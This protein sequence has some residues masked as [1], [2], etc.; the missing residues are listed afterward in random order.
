MNQASFGTSAAP[1]QPSEASLWATLADP[2]SDAAYHA[3]WLAL[4]CQRAGQIESGLLVLR[5]ADQTLAP[6]AVW[7]HLRQDVRALAE[8]AE[9][10]L[11]EA[12]PVIQ[13]FAE[14]TGS[15]VALAYPLR[16][17]AAV[18][19]VVV[20]A[21][22]PK[23]TPDVGGIIRHMHWSAGLIEAAL[24]RH[25]ASD[26]QM[27]LASSRKVMDLLAAVQDEPRLA[28]AN[29]A[30]VNEMALATKAARVSLGI[31]RRSHA[32]LAALSNSARFDRNSDAVHQIELAM[33]ECLVQNEA[34]VFPAAAQGRRQITAAHAALATRAHRGAV[35]SVPLMAVGRAVAGIV[36]IELDQDDPA[37]VAEARE[38]ALLLATLATPYIKA[39]QDG[40]RWLAGRIPRGLGAA[41]K[42]LLGRRHPGVKLAALAGV[43][44]LAF[45]SFVPMPF[46]VTARAVVEGEVQRAAV[47]PFEGFI[48]RATIRAGDT[49]AEGQEMAALDDRE[50]RFEKLKW[51][52]EKQKLEQRQREALAKYDR[53][54]VQ[55]LAAQLDQADAELRIVNEKL[56]R[57]RIVAPIAGYVV[58][59]DLTQLYG[60]P[61]QQGKVLFEI[62]PLNAYRVALAVDEVDIR[63]LTDGMAGGL[64]LTGAGAPIPITLAR[65]TSVT[66]PKDGRNT[67]R[68]EARLEGT[69]ANV[70]PG[71]EGVAKLEAGKAPLIWSWSRTL[72]D[73]MRLFFWSWMP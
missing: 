25:A 24:M 1:S 3:A 23:L 39:L 7:P 20:L 44:A 59:G 49:V 27:R 69:P 12:Q 57:A 61:V 10:A 6:A 34:V 52:S 31:V 40:D 37:L 8:T 55:V 35:L 48:Q 19:G 36:T 13:Q 43:G 47:A 21:T 70:R 56:Q 16:G 22:L 18:D 14:G 64:T 51:E 11:K 2:M 26:D 5:K 42:A 54:A 58:S 15:G 66:T 60:S 32:R 4:L 68:A 53:A 33:E 73:R 30:L 46:W 9:A 41:L 67:F 38:T 17:R 63:H 71:M 50:L 72:I 65:Q 62:A 28:R 29:I 45:I